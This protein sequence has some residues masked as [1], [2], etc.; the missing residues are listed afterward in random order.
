MNMGFRLLI[1]VSL[2]SAVMAHAQEVRVTGGFL[3]DSTSLGG[4][5]LFY[6]SAKYP[7][8]LTLLFPDSS[9]LFTPFEFSSKQ[10]FP[11]ETAGETSRDSVLYTLNTFEIDSL[12]MLS[13]PVFVVHTGDC[14]KV[15]TTPDT[16]RLRQLIIDIPDSLD[17]S[18]LPLRTR[19]SYEP[20]GKA[21]NYP[22]IAGLVVFVLALAGVTW[23]IAGKKIKRYWTIRRLQKKYGRFIQDY[24][25]SL[26]K[27]R[28]GGTVPAAEATVTVWKKYLEELEKKPF[29]K[30][31]TKETLKL[32]QEPNLE[33]QLRSI[34]KA[35]YGNH[36]IALQP[37]EALQAFANE[38]FHKKLEEVK[39]G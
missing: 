23:L 33:M 25:N 34:D 4:E 11:T 21:W 18:K 5:T 9:Y 28:T 31:T 1:I 39:H 37:F 35:I 7:K 36:E 13:L 15:F 29:T 3:Q 20:V 30:L 8:N 22:L 6:V 14:T 32:L 16:I 12:Q 27:L 17:V 24:S 38:K 26:E 19:A 2:L 10:Y